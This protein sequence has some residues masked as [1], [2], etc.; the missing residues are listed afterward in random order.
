VRSGAEAM[1]RMQETEALT[2]LVWLE[3]GPEKTSVWPMGKETGRLLDFRLDPNEVRVRYE[4]YTSGVLTLVDSYMPGWRATV[5]GRASPVLR[6][7]GVFRGIRIETPGAY[8]IH[9]RYRPEYWGLTLALA[10]IGLILLVGASWFGSGGRD[11][12]QCPT[13]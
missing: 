8:E 2:R 10:G 6:V 13:G 5:N 1:Q 4:A 11:R 7:N 12:R 9:F 3:Q